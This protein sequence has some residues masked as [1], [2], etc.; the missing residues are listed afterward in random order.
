MSETSGKAN[1][2][3][4][5]LLVTVNKRWHSQPDSVALLYMDKEPKT[6]T[7]RRDLAHVLQVIAAQPH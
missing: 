7:I 1:E 5:R 2:C 4:P 6:T 3:M